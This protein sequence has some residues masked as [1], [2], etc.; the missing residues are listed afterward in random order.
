MTAGNEQTEKDRLTELESHLAH[1][2]RFTEQLNEVVTEQA[3][4]LVI[5]RR[6]V[7]RLESQIKD[8]RERPQASEGADLF[9]E[10]PP[11]Y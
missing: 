7:T 11:H 3:G 1:L 9:D 2:Q 10:K 8:L 6:T 4:Q 5:L